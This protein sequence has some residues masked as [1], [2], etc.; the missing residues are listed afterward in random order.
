MYN[1][2][3]IITCII[4]A[5]FFCSCGG[6]G[7]GYRAKKSTCTWNNYGTITF[8]N[9]KL[10]HPKGYK[11][12]EPYNSMYPD[13]AIYSFF[14]FFEIGGTFRHPI[15]H[16]APE[17]SIKATLTA[18]DCSSATKSKSKTYTTTIDATSRS[19]FKVPKNNNF[20]DITSTKVTIKTKHHYDY[21]ER[22]S[23]EITWTLST[24]LDPTYHF[25]NGK[26]NGNAKPVP[27]YNT[28]RSFRYYHGNSFRRRSIMW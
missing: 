16:N 7:S 20:K 13:N 4:L 28:R 24:N 2:I 18:E 17:Q 3:T 26:I 5:V 8:E 23:V 25:L 15:T 11:N 21:K 22:T 10:T 19:L 9:L 27:T 12:M 6:G 14:N 1:K